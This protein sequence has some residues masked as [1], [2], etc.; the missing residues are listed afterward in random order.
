MSQ[1]GPPVSAILRVSFPAVKAEFYK[2]RTWANNKLNA[3]A[4][5]ALASITVYKGKEYEP[6]EVCT[7]ALWS[8]ADEYHGAEADRIAFVA[9][10]LKNLFQSHDDLLAHLLKPGHRLLVSRHYHHSLSDVVSTPM[11]DGGESYYVKLFT[12]F[13][14]VPL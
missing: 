4:F 10:M 2:D 9:A 12:A 13:I 11:V 8:D 7:P 3:S 5:H 1:H 6:E 14:Q